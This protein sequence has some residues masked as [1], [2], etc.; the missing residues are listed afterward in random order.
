MAPGKN[1]VVFADS[2]GRTL[3]LPSFDTDERTRA[4]DDHEVLV[5][6]RLQGSSRRSRG[7]ARGQDGRQIEGDRRATAPDEPAQH[8]GRRA[9]DRRELHEPRDLG[10]RRRRNHVDCFLAGILRM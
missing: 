3:G 7:P 1:I 2:D 6:V 4:G 5:E 9:R 8:R 10:Y